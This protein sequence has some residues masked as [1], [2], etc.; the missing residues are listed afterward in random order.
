M[1]DSQPSGRRRS[2]A[3]AGAFLGV[4]ALAVALVLAG[5]TVFSEEEPDS[6]ADVSQQTAERAGD[7]TSGA[8]PTSAAAPAST[9]GD[10]VATAVPSTVDDHGAFLDAAY[11][12]LLGRAPDGSGRQY[13][14]DRFA[15][16]TPPRVVL[17]SFGTSSEHRRFM[18]TQAYERFLRRSP[19]PG[20]VQWWAER[21]GRSRSATALWAGLAGSSEYHNTQGGGTDEGFVRALYRDALD[22]TPDSGGLAHWIGRLDTGTSRT[23]VARAI[24]ASPEAFRLSDLAVRSATPA[25]GEVVSHLDEVAFELHHPV[26]VDGSTVIVAVDG[27]RVDGAISVDDFTLRFTATEVPVWVP[28]GHRA[29]VVVTAFGYDGEAVARSDYGFSLRRGP[30]PGRTD[31]QLPRGGTELFPHHLLIAHYGATASP[32][33][34][35][36][37]EGTPAEAAQRVVDQT[38]PYEDLTDREV[39]P[40]FELIASIAHRTPTETG[41]YSTHTPFAEIEPYL[42][43][44]RSIDGL[45]LLDLQPGHATFIDHA[46]HYEPFLVQ[47]DVGLAIDPEWRMPHGQVPAT[48]IGTVDAA[49][50]NQVSAYLAEM[51]EHHDLPE[52]LLV[53][54]RFTPG[55]VTNADQVVDRDGVAIVFHADGFGTPEAKLA[56]YF[57]ILPDR[58]E[59]GMKIFFRQDTRIMSPEELMALDPPP[60]FV[61]YQ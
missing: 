27:R 58:F 7:R 32:A 8:T 34:G 4:S 45:L 23:A 55:M 10:P 24:M 38:R 39:L 14:L 35:I 40:V 43:A 22:R 56:D 51:V 26:V 48:T 42:D 28:I 47:P 49:E 2:T 5:A 33:M 46:R 36:L 20:G 9:D 6:S 11:S 29:E 19:E 16:G 30:A 21:L 25:P 57:T 13:W 17:E 50:I 31:G 59:R 37:G 1:S 41:T 54:H 60:G 12:G 52:K 61:S 3:A 44:V 53:I 18:V 15:E